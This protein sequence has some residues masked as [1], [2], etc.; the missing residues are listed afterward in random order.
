[1]RRAP[2]RQLAAALVLL[3][4]LL[5]AA[6]FTRGPQMSE[7]EARAKASF[8]PKLEEYYSKPTVETPRAT[9]PPRTSGR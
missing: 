8:V 1:M 4:V 5:F 9:T 2:N 6:G 3:V 7:Q